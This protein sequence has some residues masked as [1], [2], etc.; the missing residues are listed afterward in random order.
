MNQPELTMLNEALKRFMVQTR[1]ER[2]RL[3]ELEK[4]T[5]KVAD[6]A[7]RLQRAVEKLMELDETEETQ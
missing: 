5:R 3:S 7:W 6:Y 2:V 1:A 4:R